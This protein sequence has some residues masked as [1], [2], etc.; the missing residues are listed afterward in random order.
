VADANAL[1]LSSAMTAEAWVYAD[2]SSQARTILAKEESSGLVYGLFLTSTSQLELRVKAGGTLRTVTSVTSIP[3]STWTH[4]AGT[5]DGAHLRVWINGLEENS[6][7][8]TGSITASD[9]PLRIGGDTVVNQPFA[10][11]A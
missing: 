9:Q 11:L 10:G 5:Y 2:A 1:D 6:L 7:A 8:A 3:S 4:V